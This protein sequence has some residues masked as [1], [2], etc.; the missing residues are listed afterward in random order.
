MASLIIVGYLSTSTLDGAWN[1]TV[2][3]IKEA[4]EYFKCIRDIVKHTININR[5]IWR[6]IDLAELALCFYPPID[7]EKPP[8]EI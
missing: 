7:P 4:R 5:L 8:Y 1:I 3:G 2:D 6:D